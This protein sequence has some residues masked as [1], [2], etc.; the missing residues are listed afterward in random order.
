MTDHENSLSIKDR[1]R[2]AM[3]EGATFRLADVDPIKMKPAP[4]GD[5]FKVVK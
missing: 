4:H 1:L 3:E 5:N 2:K